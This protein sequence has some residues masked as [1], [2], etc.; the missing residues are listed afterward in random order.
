MEP[1][2]ID[3]VDWRGKHSQK[4]FNLRIP[5]AYIAALNCSID[6][7][8]YLRL[9]ATITELRPC[10]VTL[11]DQ[12]AQKPGQKNDMD[13]LSVFV[14]NEY[15]DPPEK[16]WRFW[17]EDTVDKTRRPTR[18]QN[19]YNV[20]R[21]PDQFGLEH[22]RK[23]DCGDLVKV[24]P[25][26]VNARAPC[27]DI[28]NEIFVSSPKARDKV[29]YTCALLEASG[30]KNCTAFATHKGWRMQYTFARGMISRWKEI[31]TA[32]HKLVARFEVHH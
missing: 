20:Y 22:Y 28:D 4:T 32:A 17:Y 13:R 27:H 18:M 12:L 14:G 5:R 10:G 16:R 9:D 25:A 26:E 30:D 29:Y 2:D 8:I 23:R 6:G 24:V 19:L 15:F 11:I 7:E 21:L 3:F 31:D 1:L